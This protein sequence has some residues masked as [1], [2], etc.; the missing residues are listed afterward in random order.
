MIKKTVTCKDFN[1]KEYT[2]DYYFNLT[3]AEAID[4]ET[5]VSGGLTEHLKKLIE[6]DNQ[7][8]TMKF[9]RELVRKA[10]GVKSEDGRRFIKDEKIVTEFTQTNAYSEIYMELA[11]NDVAAA[12][13]V[14]GILPQNLAQSIEKHLKASGKLAAPTNN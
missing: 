14:N 2:E 6:T 8:E 7:P 10:Y 3:E 1:G 4:M 11:I 5:S 12:E 13:F 9:F